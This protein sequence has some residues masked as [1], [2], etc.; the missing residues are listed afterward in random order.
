[1]TNTQTLFVSERNEQQIP[2]LT[3]NEENTDTSDTNQETSQSET[4]QN[5]QEDITRFLQLMDE[6]N[7]A[8]LEYEDD[9]RKIRLQKQGSRGQSQQPQQVPSPG[10]NHQGAP[11][12]PDESGPTEDTEDNQTTS[13]ET[14]TSPLV[15]TFYRAPNPDEDPFVE[16][17]D[18]I[19]ESTVVCIVEAMKV[20]NEIK[21]EMNG[22]IQE[23]L[24][25]DGESVEFGQPLFKVTDD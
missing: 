5:A 7:L 14:I 16:K 21:A 1:M 25:E 9:D 13:T 11:T 20:M 10:T 3:M 23:I 24:V 4:P 8:E 15:G 18:E 17:G 19:S 12:Q 6:H 2:E 22:V